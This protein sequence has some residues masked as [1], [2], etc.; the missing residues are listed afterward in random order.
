LLSSFLHEFEEHLLQSASLAPGTAKAH[1]AYAASLERWLASRGVAL[2]A[3]SAADLRAYRQSLRKSSAGAWKRRLRALFRLYGWALARGMCRSN[4]TAGLLMAPPEAMAP[5]GPAGDE[6]ALERLL[7]PP[8]SH[9]PTLWRDH[10]LLALMHECGFSISEVL[11]LRLAPAGGPAAGPERRV[12]QTRSAQV[13]LVLR[14]DLSAVVVCDPN[15]SEREVITLGAQAR[16]ALL[17]Y[18]PAARLSLLA[19]HG[20]AY[21]FVASA[22]RRP[23]VPETASGD[24]PENS[25]PPLARQVAWRR[26]E[27][28]ARQSG[29]QA[30]RP[31]DLARRLSEHWLSTRVG[32]LSGAV[33]TP[34]PPAAPETPTP[35]WR[36]VSRLMRGT[37]A[38]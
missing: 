20:S 26:L 38:L 4:P 5:P 11:Q 30:T 14:R 37:P 16:D 10:A 36:R 22:S 23:K 33:E 15:R 31:T 25:V 9:V 27:Q 1:A 17:G 32:T 8:R 6:A 29:L 13:G 34:D 19:G 24:G 3:A 2:L 12:W 7:S 35:S 21:V 18:L 28:R